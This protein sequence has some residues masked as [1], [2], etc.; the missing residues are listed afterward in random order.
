MNLIEQL[1]DAKNYLVDLRL[2]IKA[3]KEKT[4]NV[5]F[6]KKSDDVKLKF[7]FLPTRCDESNKLLWLRKVYEVH[8]DIWFYRQSQFEGIVTVCRHFSQQEYVKLLLKV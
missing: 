8:A 1:I 4:D 3:S 5:E 7:L 2:M 6:I